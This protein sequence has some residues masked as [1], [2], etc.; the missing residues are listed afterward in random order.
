MITERKKK[1]EK[2]IIIKN[3]TFNIQRQVQFFLSSSKLAI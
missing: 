3:F 2:G 1:E